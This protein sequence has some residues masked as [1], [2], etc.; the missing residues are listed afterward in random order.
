MVAVGVRVVVRAAS[1]RI[2]IRGRALR[3]IPSKASRLSPR[4]LVNSWL[5]MACATFARYCRLIS[6]E[7]AS[8][9]WYCISPV[10][11]SS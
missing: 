10:P 11:S 8:R 1:T 9:S 2:V 5:A 3:S 6:D 4:V 7:K